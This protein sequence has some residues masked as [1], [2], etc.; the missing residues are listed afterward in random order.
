M[1]TQGIN[2][3]LGGFGLEH[4]LVDIVPS[5]RLYVER[6]LADVS[7]TVVGKIAKELEIEPPK[8]AT[9]ITRNLT[10]YLKTEGFQA[11]SHDFERALEYLG[12]DPD[13]HLAVHLQHSKAYVKPYLIAFMN[14]CRRK[15]AFSR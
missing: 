5:K 10:E 1:N 11:A 2:V 13:K 9:A 4:E 8:T 3:F 15:K 14:L 6:L 7:D 12:S